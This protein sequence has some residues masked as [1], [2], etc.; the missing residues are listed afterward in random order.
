MIAIIGRHRVEIEFQPETRALLVD[1]SADRA[2]IL[3]GV[4]D[5]ISGDGVGDALDRDAPTL[6]A[7]D[8]L[9]NGGVSFIG[10]G[11]SPGVAAAS[12]RDARFTPPPMMV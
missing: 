10:N 12:S 1:E 11:I 3:K 2:G 7:L 5:L 6:I 8:P 9:A 4:D